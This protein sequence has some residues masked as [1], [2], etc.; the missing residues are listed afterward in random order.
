MEPKYSTSD[1]LKKCK[2]GKGSFG[3][4]YLVEHKEKGYALKEVNKGYVT[5]MDRTESV[6]RERDLLSKLSK[7]PGF[8]ELLATF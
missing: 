7:H 5:R 1:F 8:P 3:N 4:V 6:F 2:L